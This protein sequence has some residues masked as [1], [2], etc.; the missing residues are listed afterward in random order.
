MAFLSTFWADFIKWTHFDPE[1]KRWTIPVELLKTR[2]TKRKKH[3]HPAF[4]TRSILVVSG[5]DPFAPPPLPALQPV[6]LSRQQQT[7]RVPHLCEALRVGPR[8]ALLSAARAGPRVVSRK[9]CGNYASSPPNHV[10]R[11]RKEPEASKWQPQL[12]ISSQNPSVLLC[13]IGVR[14][15]DCHHPSVRLLLV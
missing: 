13:P 8:P 14:Y 7:P 15:G 12:C 2:H 1:P 4:D 10:L 11:R 5:F 9:S 3:W 6:L